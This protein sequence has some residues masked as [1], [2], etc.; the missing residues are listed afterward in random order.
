VRQAEVAHGPP[1]RI[2]VKRRFTLGRCQTVTGKRQCFGKLLD[3]PDSSER[4]EGGLDRPQS[5]SANRTDK[6]GPANTGQATRQYAIDSSA[7][8]QVSKRSSVARTRPSPGFFFRSNQSVFF[9]DGRY[10]S[11]RADVP[12]VCRHFASA[13][14]EVP[15][16]R[17]CNF[18]NSKGHGLGTVLRSLCRTKKWSK[19]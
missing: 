5:F 3:R 6:G 18:F 8:D 10:T 15:K 4:H 13:R 16:R 2:P 19:T 7:P 12:F 11:T 17:L 1:T 9:P 14:A